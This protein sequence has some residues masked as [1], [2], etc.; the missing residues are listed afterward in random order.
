MVDQADRVLREGE[1][2]FNLRVNS[3][4]R[5]MRFLEENFSRYSV[6]AYLGTEMHRML[7]KELRVE[8]V[9]RHKKKGSN[10]A[11][12]SLT[13]K[14]ARVAAESDDSL[15]AAL[16]V[17]LAGN[18]IDFG[19]YNAEVD[20]AQLEEALE[21]RPEINHYPRA[22]E[23]LSSPKSILY[24]ADNAGEIALDRFLIEELLA[25]G[26]KVVVAVKSRPIVN[27]A[28]MEDVK[29]VGLEGICRVIALGTD[30]IGVAMEETSPEFREAF[31]AAELVIS[32]GQGNF[33]TLSDSHGNILFLFK[34]KCEH[35]TSLLDIDKNS[36]VI[37]LREA[38]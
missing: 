21:D 8:D 29:E 31:E 4:K 15:L 2:D 24:I 5:A 38:K 27:D 19:A 18:L 30:S 36:S 7:K 22:R 20:P 28:T 17:S 12:L 37:M 14:A 25:R 11:A 23:L 35:I 3:L 10:A 16:K 9:Y 13:R 33:E 26:H 34:A 1:A 32:K 6:P